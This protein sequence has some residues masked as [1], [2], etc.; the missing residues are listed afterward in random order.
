[1]SDIRMLP[2]E[3]AVTATFVSAV[4]LS[5]DGKRIAYV[6]TPASKE[7][8][9]PVSTLWL[10][11]A[12]GETPRRMMASECADGNPSWS[13][14]G[15]WLAF[16]SDRLD[17]GKPQA[18]VL[19]LDG[20]EA[21]RLTD[22]SGG[23]GDV[24]WSPDG[25]R[26]AFTARDG[27]TDDHRQRK[28]ERRDWK[29]VDEDVK[30][31]SLWILDAPDVPATLQPDDLPEAR[32]ISP[33]GLNIGPGGTPAFDWSPDGTAIATVA[34][35]N[36]KAHYLF[37]PDLVVIS[38]DG[39]LTN[40]GNFEGLLSVPR[41][42]PNGSTI[43]FI[44]CETVMPSLYCLRTIPAG[45]GESRVAIPG[46][47]GS[48]LG[49]GWLPDGD[50]MVALTEERQSHL[51]RIVDPESR[52]LSNAIGDLP[53]GASGFGAPPP[54]VS[55]DGTRVAFTRGDATSLPD[56][57]VA[58]LGGDA[59]RL[60]DLNPWVRDYDFGETR[61]ARWTSFDGMEIEGLLILPVGY[62]VGHRYPT[63]LHIHGGSCGAFN[64]ELFANWHDWGQF[65]AQRGYA[66]LLPNPR[67]SSGRGSEFLC[68]IVG[69][70]GEPDFQDLMTGIDWLIAE[71]IADPDQLVV[72]GWSGGGFLTNWAITHTNGFKA[73]V[74][75]A[76]ISNWVSFQ[77]TA[78]VRSV[79]DR[80]LNPVVEDPETHWRLSP[81][82]YIR[83]ATT[84]TLI[85]Y[86]E[87][88]E[89]V[90]VTQGYELYEGLRARGVETQLVAYPRQPH[91]I[92]ER[93]HQLDLLERVVNWYDRH[94]GREN[95]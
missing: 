46:F 15:R 43:G 71:G 7:G 6:T 39:E 81:I 56:V 1:M 79:F 52:D 59:R 26:L 91:G 86:G 25:R 45:G 62:Q 3:R 28:D 20:G 65:M 4:Q 21:I 57:W 34:T 14:D 5:P 11:D 12:D 13:P 55:K 36:P 92:Q 78:D 77:G 2:F 70:Y 75:G 54:S 24:S 69:C 50:R 18:Y 42:S 35:P 63:L 40:L 9:H 37:A 76:G 72:G 82:R 67:G 58:D 68:E 87:A 73:A 31:T 61:E 44:G 29:V 51:L 27:E 10:I 41:F 94:L 83:D 60:T 74:S 8:E 49:F 80:Y 33:E 19:Q 85:L 32:R 90:P 95:V 38:L 47:E 84:P 16:T 89:R 66:V 88:D 23:I 64:M 30:L 22:A 17:R 53:A 48:F 93:K